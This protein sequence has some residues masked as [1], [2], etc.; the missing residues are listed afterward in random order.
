MPDLTIV[1]D[2]PV[3]A[4]M[5]RIAKRR[6][7]AAAD[8]FEAE[9]LDFHKKLRESYLDLA[10]REPSRCVPVDASGDPQSVSNAVWAVVNARL[11]PAE[12]PALIQDAA[13]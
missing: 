6:G 7:N 2:V 13:S 9:D 11:Q 8:R 3:S 10:E 1:L 4:G 5:E 12:A